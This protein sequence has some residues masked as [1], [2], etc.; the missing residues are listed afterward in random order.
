MVSEIKWKSA[1]NYSA[2]LTFFLQIETEYGKG[3]WSGN[4]YR[5]VVAFP[6]DGEEITRENNGWSLCSSSMNIKFQEVLKLSVVTDIG[7]H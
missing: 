4:I 2:P 7:K 5:D 1:K 3:A 6:G